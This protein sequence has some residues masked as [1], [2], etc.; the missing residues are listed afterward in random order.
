MRLNRR[1]V[2]IAF[3]T[4][5]AV[6]LMATIVIFY[7]LQTGWF[8]D[9]VRTRIVASV[10]RATGGRVELGS[11]R[12]DWRT[13]SVELRRF[14]LHGTEPAG[15][16]PLFTSDS[17]YVEL[18]VLS[19]VKRSV[20]LSAVRV[21][22]PNL[23]LLI[24][25]DGTTNLPTPKIRRP[26]GKRVLEQLVDLK[27][28]HFE[29]N[30]G[31][32]QTNIQRVPLNVHA[33]DV[34]ALLT[35]DLAAPRYNF[36]VASQQLR[37]ASSITVP[38]AGGLRVDG[39]LEKDRLLLQ[40]IQYILPGSEINADL[41]LTHFIRP[42]VDIHVDAG[43]AASEVSKVM[44][45]PELRSGEVKVQGVAHYDASTPLN[46]Q[47][48]VRGTHLVYMTRSFGLKGFALESDVAADRKGVVLKRLSASAL[49]GVL[50]G[51][52]EIVGY[53]NLKLAGQISGLRDS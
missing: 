23:Y 44:R 8:M 2:F 12:Y 21:Q 1:N 22:G 9:Q 29:W 3:T 30:N 20:D 34:T 45:F 46:F 35:Y 4:G 19:L 53:Q 42:T 14:T 27:I 39:Q 7:V 32:V 38:A 36:H 15:S 10:E 25:P 13:L 5:I 49:G 17:I 51:E 41:A 6:L 18:K 11:L 28:K 47:G 40:K 33:S 52:G 24:R 50:R 16:P 26:N 48:K 31:T 37:V 43:L